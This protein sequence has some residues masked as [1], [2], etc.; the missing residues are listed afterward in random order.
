MIL[1]RCGIKSIH[2]YGLYWATQSRTIKM[3]KKNSSQLHPII[4]AFWYP[5][6]FFFL[7]GDTPTSK[8]TYIGNTTNITP[9]P[10]F[11]TSNEVF[12]SRDS[13]NITKFGRSRIRPS[14]SR[15]YYTIYL[16]HLRLTFYQ[17]SKSF[18]GMNTFLHSP[19]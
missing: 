11:I 8:C 16:L 13:W 12:F 19:I 6:I 10:T 15:T 1:F 7:G 14:F 9:P 3:K 4:V 17:S 2:I 5:N 18:R